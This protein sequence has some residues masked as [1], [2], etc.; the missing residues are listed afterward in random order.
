MNLIDNRTPSNRAQYQGYNNSHQFISIHYLGVDGENPN[1]YGDGYG[2][3]YTIMWNGDVYWSADH[4][5]VLWQVGTAGCYTKKYPN[6]WD[7]TNYN[8]IGVE[9]CCHCTN[10]HWWFTEETQKACVELVMFLMATLN[11]SEDRVLRHFDIVN[12]DCPMPYVLNDKYKTSWTWDEFKSKL[13]AK[14][15]D[16]LVVEAYN[17]Y[18]LEKQFNPPVMRYVGVDRLEVKVAPSDDSPRHP[19]WGYLSR[20]NGVEV[21]NTFNSGYA[22][23]QMSLGRKGTATMGFVKARNLYKK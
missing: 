16:E 22:T 23:V 18:R 15:E 8:S 1:L 6:G 11:I 12:K 9:M 4:Y 17:K 7:V 5:A 13:R 10:G 19:Y 14:G 3:H 2:G 21:Y 20:D